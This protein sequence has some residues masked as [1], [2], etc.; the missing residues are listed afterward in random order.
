M[1]RTL[2]VGSTLY[3]C[4]CGQLV[5]LR[6]RDKQ[7]VHIGYNRIHEPYS[8]FLKRTNHPVV[9]THKKI[10]KGLKEGWT[11]EMKKNG[12]WNEVRENVWFKSFR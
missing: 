1:K 3:Y 6:K 12:R 5:R 7:W 8:D 11:Y 2:K 10:W 9:I 4:K